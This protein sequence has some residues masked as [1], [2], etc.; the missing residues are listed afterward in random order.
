MIDGLTLRLLLTRLP[1]TM[2]DVLTVLLRLL[3]SILPSH[4][5]EPKPCPSYRNL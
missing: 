1:G 5:L 2:K 3:L 4:A